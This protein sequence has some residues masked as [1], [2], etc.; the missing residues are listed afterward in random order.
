MG[1]IRQT[2]GHAADKEDFAGWRINWST[3]SENLR[4]LAEELRLGLDSFILLDDSSLECSEVRSNCPEVLALQL[5]EER[6]VPAFLRHVWALD[7]IRVTEDDERRTERYATERKRGEVRASASS[8]QA[9]LHDLE[10]VMSIKEAEAGQLPRIAQLMQRTNQFTLNADRSMAD[11]LPA[12]L[13][14]PDTACWAI[15]A[16]DRFGSYGLAGAVITDA[17]TASCIWILST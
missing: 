12:I 17:R 8:L 9:F 10:L 3:K 13:S 4:S 6:Q 14:K 16:A 1:R 5:P 2:S 11:G 15:E 7:R